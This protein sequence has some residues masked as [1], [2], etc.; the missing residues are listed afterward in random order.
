M[1]ILI[2]VSLFLFVIAD[3]IL[4]DTVNDC[5]KQ[6]DYLERKDEALKFIINTHIDN[7]KQVLK[8]YGINDE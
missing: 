7:A 4:F 8:E 5:K 3:I 6:V 1:N 2:Y